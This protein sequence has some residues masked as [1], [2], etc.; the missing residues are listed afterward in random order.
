M[1]GEPPSPVILVGVIRVRRHCTFSWQR[2]ETAVV[3]TVEVRSSHCTQCIAE[4]R[5][6]GLQLVNADGSAYSS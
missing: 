2:V 3:R 5:Q 6:R 1:A 4:L